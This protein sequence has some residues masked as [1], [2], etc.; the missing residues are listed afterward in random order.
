M[1]RSDY[2]SSSTADPVAK[3]DDFAEFARSESGKSVRA[4]NGATGEK[5]ARSDL[6]REFERLCVAFRLP[7]FE[8]QYLFATAV[9]RRYRFDLCWPEYRL[10]IELHG[11]VVQ[12][13]RV[14]GAHGGI[15]G[16]ITKDM[17]KANLAVMLGW[18]LLTF[19][20]SH[21]YSS[22]AAI[23]MTQRVLTTKGWKR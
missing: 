15:V 8:R 17:D 23:D 3:S 9:A 20:Q 16:G 18:S 13:G 7:A 6:E 19:T 12:K 1:R 2:S 4:G 21:V 14:R 5:Y 22:T 10:A 11:L